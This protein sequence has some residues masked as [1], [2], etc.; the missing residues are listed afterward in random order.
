MDIDSL[1]LD[2]GRIFG[3][4]FVKRTTGET[5]HMVCRTGVK[6]HLKGGGR[7]Y[8]PKAKG[9]LNVYDVQKQGYRSI[10]IENV[11]QIEHHGVVTQ[12]PLFEQV[13]VTETA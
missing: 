13:H 2:D 12:G 1:D 4:W 7:S 5:R 11:I 6:K 9:L 8:D 10:P 3:V